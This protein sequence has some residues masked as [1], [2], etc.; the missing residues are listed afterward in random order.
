MGLYNV[1]IYGF[2]ISYKHELTTTSC[3]FL[4]SGSLRLN[5]HAK[6][7]DLIMLAREMK[8]FQE[9]FSSPWLSTSLIYSPFWREAAGFRCFSQ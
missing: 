5:G 3:I 6:S 7:S 8:R 1:R 2:R 4:A 9:T